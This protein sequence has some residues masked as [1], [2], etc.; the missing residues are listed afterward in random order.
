MS[1]YFVTFRNEQVAAPLKQ[2]QLAKLDNV[3]ATF[4]NEQVAA[5]LK[6]G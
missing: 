5:P 3:I 4:R 2:Y 1:R 6:R